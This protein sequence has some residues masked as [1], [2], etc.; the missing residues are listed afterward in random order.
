MDT[1]EYPNT[2]ATPAGMRSK[3]R[4]IISTPDGLFVI[5][6]ITGLDYLESATPLIM[7]AAAKLKGATETIR[8][9]EAE[10][11]AKKYEGDA[12]SLTR[13]IITRGVVP[14]EI[15]RD[16]EDWTLED[17]AVGEEVREKTQTFGLTLTEEDTEDRISAY[18]LSQ[19][20][21][22]L[23]IRSIKEIS[24]FG[25]AADLGDRLRNFRVGEPVSDRET[26]D[27]VFEAPE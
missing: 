8:Q 20:T 21:I 13:V 2:V 3:S 24:G 22:L 5:R 15:Y 12:A 4:R 23:L 14:T 10:R 25:P 16:G 17:S 19:E 6:R 26:S 18:N 27:E 7:E 1:N 9:K 11:L